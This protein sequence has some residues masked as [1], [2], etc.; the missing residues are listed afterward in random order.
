MKTLKDITADKGTIRSQILED[1]DGDITYIK[2]VASHGCIGG[3][4]RNL[5]YY[6]DTKKFYQDHADE[7]D[8]LLQEYED[9]AGESI[10]KTAN[11]NGNLQNF[12]AWFAYEY[13]AQKIMREIDPDNY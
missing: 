13:E 12:L 10:L 8:E 11:T 3:A 9:A 7:I 5:I 1:A 4:C 2:D 6:N